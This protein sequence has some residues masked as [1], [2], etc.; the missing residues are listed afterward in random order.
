M[1]ASVD[2]T[3]LG[4]GERHAEFAM[5]W[6]E[7]AVTARDA[8]ELLEADRAVRQA[9]AVAGQVV[10]RARDKGIVLRTQ[11]LIALELGRFAEASDVLTGLIGRSAERDEQALQRRLLSNAEL[12]Q[13]HAAAALAA[14]DEALSMADPAGADPEA[15]FARQARARALSLQGQGDAALADMQIVEQGLAAARYAPAALPVLRA[16]RLVAEMLARQGKLEA[17]WDKLAPVVQALD[18][19]AGGSAVERGLAL[20]L[21]GCIERDR[22]RPGAAATLHEQA[23]A[24]LAT[25]L[26]P[27]HAFLARNVLY[28]ER[29]R[30]LVSNTPEAALRY[31]GL[32]QAYGQRFGPAS[33]WSRL[34]AA[35]RDPA[36]C[37]LPAPRACTLIL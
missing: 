10:L 25:Q 4:F 30:S 6:N 27:D 2:D 9:L 22:G 28:Q 23:H 7:L 5:A 32:A 34:I 35:Q 16:Q 17:A 37:H 31:E 3:A 11:A 18:G 24:L 1:R 26:P 13:G 36:A 21:Q 20:D 8:G 15:L 29:A 14:A 12:A 33:D 19:S